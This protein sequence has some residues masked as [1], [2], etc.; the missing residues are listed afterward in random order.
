MTHQE[1]LPEEFS[2]APEWA[3]TL[4]RECRASYDLGFRATYRPDRSPPSFSLPPDHP[5][6]K[7]R[8]RMNKGS[9]SP[10]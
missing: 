2:D 6:S 1:D 3:R 4:W 5:L 9:E 10:A 7:M 8:A